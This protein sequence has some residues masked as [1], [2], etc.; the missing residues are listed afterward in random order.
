MRRFR[1]T[2]TVI[3]LARLLSIFSPLQSLSRVCEHVCFDLCYDSN[4]KQNVQAFEL[5]L[6]SVCYEKCA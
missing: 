4:S 2:R 5:E 6:D 1:L 3:H